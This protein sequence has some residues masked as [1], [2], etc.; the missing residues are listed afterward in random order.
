MTLQR[1]LALFVVVA[2]L[3][4]LV[5]VAFAV[6]GRAQGELSRRAAAEH[7]ARARAGAVAIAAELAEVDGALTALADTWRPDRLGEAELRG[8]LV[9]LS[10]QV[11]AADASA[12]L[13]GAGSVRAVFAEGGGA[14]TDAFVAA[15]RSSGTAPAGRL[16]LSAYDD[17]GN[18]WRLAALRA[19]AAGD[20][21]RWL[22]GV[23]LGAD[24]A[25][26]RLDASVPEG[27][28]A[29]LIDGARVLLASS[30]AGPLA[31]E[32][33]ADLAGRLDPSRAGAVQGERVLGAY[34]PLEDG[35]GW[36]VLVAV[37]AATAYAQIVSMRR[38]VLVASV[39]VLASVLVLSFLLGR[40]TVAGLARIES[41]AR[42]LG[43]G[44]LAVRLPVLGADEVA[45]VSRTFNGMAAELQ[46][47]REH[48]ERWNEELQREVEAR[49]RELKEAQARLVETQK[50]AAIGQLGAGVAHEINN[51]L[52]GILGNAQLL[53]DAGRDGPADREVLG[54]IEMLA[55]RCR[56]IT[57]NLLRFS[58]QR[59]EPDFRTLDVDAVVR[60]ALTLAEEQVRAAGLTLTLD[61]AEPAPRV[62]GDAGH[63]AQVVLH[64]VSNAR[65]ACLGRKGGAIE[66]TT[67]Q[68]G[69]EVRIAVKD[70]GK[71]IVPEHL[72]RIFEPF[73]TTK[74]QWSNVGLGLSVS[75]R[76]VSEHR[77]RIRVE[78]RPG[79]G[80]TFTVCLPALPPAAMS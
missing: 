5:G 34:A 29:Y 24:A 64:L 80:S 53:L 60:D 18:G 57:Q 22:V 76:I 65:T 62:A 39:A 21:R 40:G 1:K 67:R 6:L 30:G 13:D 11:P 44:E 61:L 12:V 38:G 27:G 55:R 58:Q 15:V 46:R 36:G 37:P 78:S 41:A 26:R 73:F 28:A 54:K 48:L 2:A 59:A 51:P 52:T 49:T 72:P 70:N 71:G 14:A 68:E 77:G 79:E 33:R 32:Q 74:D 47:A 7:L 16:V 43:A 31:P 17:P 8:M 75:Y 66:V 10:R 63:L 25:R 50:L 56:D 35:T 45:Q 9:V 3:A 69:G 20:G 19:V 42:A 23:R 4:P